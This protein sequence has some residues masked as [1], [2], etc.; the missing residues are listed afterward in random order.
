MKIYFHD[1][2]PA[3]PGEKHGAR[4]PTHCATATVDFEYQ[5]EQHV[6]DAPEDLPH[7]F[8]IECPDIGREWTR[9]EGE[10]FIQVAPAGQPI[11]SSKEKP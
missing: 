11:N 9:T 6:L 3:A 4:G 2:T 10:P 5:V 1:N 8:R 7:V